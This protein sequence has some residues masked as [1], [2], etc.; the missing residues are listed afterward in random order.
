M[1]CPKAVL[2]L[3][4]LIFCLS[5]LIKETHIANS[6][7]VINNQTTYKEISKICKGKTFLINFK[8]EC[9]VINGNKVILCYNK[10]DQTVNADIDLLP[11]SKTSFNNA[12]KEM[13]LPNE[14]ATN[15]YNK[16]HGNL[17]S[18]IRVIPGNA[19]IGSPKW[20]TQEHLDLLAPIL[21]LRNFDSQETEIWIIPALCTMKIITL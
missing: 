19:A 18:L 2:L 6:V 10:E 11:L 13:E 14:I 7:I 5:A 1:S 21:L 20:S 16:T 8:L 15:L 3:D 9:D 12:I 4:K 17:L